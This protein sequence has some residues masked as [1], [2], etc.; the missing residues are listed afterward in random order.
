QPSRIPTPPK[1]ARMALPP[2]SQKTDQAG[3]G[4]PRRVL[5][6]HVAGGGC[7]PECTPSAH[8]QQKSEG[9]A[10][11]TLYG[12]TSHRGTTRRASPDRRLAT[13]L[14]SPKISKRFYTNT[15]QEKPSAGV[16]MVGTLH[17]PGWNAWTQAR[18][19]NSRL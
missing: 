1:P 7:T 17:K 11:V 5:C 14:G 6:S 4:P 2:L 15:R 9:L 18:I 3:W 16:A 10:P 8:R 13:R 19:H 12:Y